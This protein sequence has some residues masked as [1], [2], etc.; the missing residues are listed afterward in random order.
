MFD[1]QLT[2][3]EEVSQP[4]DRPWAAWGYLGVEF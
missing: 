1:R 3:S 2:D 4:W